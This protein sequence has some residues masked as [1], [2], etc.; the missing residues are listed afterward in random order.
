M[1]IFADNLLTVI[2][3]L[4]TEFIYSYIPFLNHIDCLILNRDSN[5]KTLP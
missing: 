5:L 4:E 2:F 1:V 3:L